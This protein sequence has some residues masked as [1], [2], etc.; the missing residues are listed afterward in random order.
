MALPGDLAEDMVR[1]AVV[2]VDGD[3]WIVRHQRLGKCLW[4]CV[5]VRTVVDFWVPLGCTQVHTVARSSTLVVGSSVQPWAVP[6][7]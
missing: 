2:G 1:I 3:V 5:C 4:A 7:S 6:D